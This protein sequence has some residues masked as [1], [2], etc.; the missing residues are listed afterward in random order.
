MREGP[1]RLGADIYRLTE[2]LAASVSRM[3]L[4]SMARG[5]LGISGITC[6]AAPTN[7]QLSHETD[8]FTGSVTRSWS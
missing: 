5:L 4:G 6:L 7:D 2:R 1:S 3:K 8:R